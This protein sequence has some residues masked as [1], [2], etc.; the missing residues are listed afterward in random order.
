MKE[1]IFYMSNKEIDWAW[2]YPIYWDEIFRT[3]LR[4]SLVIML[5][6]HLEIVLEETTKFI[7]EVI[8]PPL[9]IKEVSKGSAEVYQEANV[10]PLLD[11][12]SLRFVFV[13]VRFLLAS[14]LRLFL[15]IQFQPQ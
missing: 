10:L 4:S 2:H 13:V 15:L 5:I 6:S 11:Y 7:Q 14:G 12:Q 8:E 1:D 9:K 3:R